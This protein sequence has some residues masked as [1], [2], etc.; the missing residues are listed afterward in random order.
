MECLEYK[1]LKLKRLNSDEN[2]ESWKLKIEICI[3]NV[4]NLKFWEFKCLNWNVWILKIENSLCE[5]FG[6]WIFENL[7]FEM[8]EFGCVNTEN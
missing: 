4:W 1:N 7:K 3:W 5:V 6:I 8:L 2:I